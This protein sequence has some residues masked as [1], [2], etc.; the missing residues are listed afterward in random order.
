MFHSLKNLVFL[1]KKWHFWKSFKKSG[2]FEKTVPNP[3][4]HHPQPEPEPTRPKKSDKP[5]ASEISS[6]GFGIKISNPKPE[7]P[8]PDAPEPEKP[9]PCAPLPTRIAV[10]WFGLDSCTIVIQKSIISG[11]D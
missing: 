11:F 6:D 8:E 3:K 2:I 7:K 4:F 10:N 5:D 9:D 1:Q